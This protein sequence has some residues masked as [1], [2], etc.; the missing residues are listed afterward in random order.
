MYEDDMCGYVTC[1]HNEM[2]RCNAC[3]RYTYECTWFM[4]SCSCNYLDTQVEVILSLFAH[5]SFICH[6]NLCINL[7]YV[8]IKLH[9]HL[10][11]SLTFNTTYISLTSPASFYISSCI[12]LY[13][14]IY[15]Y[16]FFQIQTTC[17]L[18]LAA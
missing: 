8:Y 16:L 10:Y 7:T 1:L 2:R 6:L 5:K 15:P 3:I 13:I 17:T 11:I 18:L 12:S 9:S 14:P 4:T